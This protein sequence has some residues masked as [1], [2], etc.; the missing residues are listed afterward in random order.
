MKLI[1]GHFII[2][3]TSVYQSTKRLPTFKKLTL[4]NKLILFLSI[5]FSFSA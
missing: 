5:K 3:S 2:E 1:L 4:I